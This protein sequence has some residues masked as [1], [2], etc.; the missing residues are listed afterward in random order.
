MAYKVTT[1]EVI[2]DD[3][4]A[5]FYDVIVGVNHTDAYIFQGFTSGY[6]SGGWS[7]PHRNTID[8]FPF[9][10]DANATDVGDLTQG[11][12]NL[13]GQSSSTSGYSS[14]GESPTLANTIDKFLFASDANAT[15]VGNLTQARRAHAGHSSSESGYSSGGE[16][17]PP[18]VNTIDKFSFS[19]DANAT[20]VG[21]LTD[22]RQGHSGT[23]SADNG[24]AA[25]GWSPGFVN[26]IDKFPFSSDANATDVGDLTQARGDM[27]AG[28]SSTTNG[29]SSGGLAGPPIV[30]Q[31]TID[32]FP[33]ASD[34]NATDV[35]D[36]TTARQDGGGQSSTTNGYT[37]GG[38][39]GNNPAPILNI[40]EKFPFSTDANATD[41]GDLTQARR[42]TTGQQV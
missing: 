25:G 31:T 3:K 30:A 38:A 5:V 12:F 41:V 16:V 33:F 20:D 34:A 21:D 8:K 2:K 42:D 18:G 28:Q 10:S 17:P 11:R 26:V 27:H 22:A 4:T 15:D 13:S 35:G 9:G 39:V 7:P 36:T 6:T 14:G 40:I 24:Y 29:Y 1:S 19:T 32:K 23:S 37:S